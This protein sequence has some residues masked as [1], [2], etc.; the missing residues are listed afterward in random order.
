MQSMK[1]LI[2]LSWDRSLCVST[3]Y[4]AFG[5][6]EPVI[7]PDVLTEQL[8]EFTGFA[9]YETTFVLD[10]QKRYYWKYQIPLEV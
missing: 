6:P 2:A 8:S 10:S 5:D 9:C 3:E 1:V 4:P 7:L